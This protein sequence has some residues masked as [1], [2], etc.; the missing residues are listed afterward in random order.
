MSKE[1]HKWISAFTIDR[2]LSRGLLCSSNRGAQ[3]GTLYSIQHFPP[4]MRDAMYVALCIER[5]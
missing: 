2:E 1:F 3:R 4:K 5:L